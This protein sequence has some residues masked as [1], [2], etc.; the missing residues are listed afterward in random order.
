MM[1]APQVSGRHVAFAR[2]TDLTGLWSGEYW[3]AGVSYPTP[4]TAHII[5]SAGDLS[6]TT[7]EPNRFAAGAPADLS[8]S[9][10]G[11]RGNGSVR[12]TKVYD[13]APGLH[14][15]PIHYSGS[16]DANFTLIDGVWTFARP[17]HPEGRFILVRVRPATASL[18]VSAA[19]SAHNRA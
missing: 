16:V 9:L 6:G 5:D 19:A 10:T 12:F 11:S 8:A 1:W 7:L 17:N 14:R 2:D 18:A 13:A 15:L 3:Y 4:F